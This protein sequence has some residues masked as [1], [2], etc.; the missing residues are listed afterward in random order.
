MERLSWKW[1]CEK[2]NYVSYDSRRVKFDGD[3][4]NCRTEFIGKFW[5]W[6]KQV[7]MP[8]WI[9]MSKTWSYQHSKRRKKLVP[10]GEEDTE[11][12]TLDNWRKSMQ[13]PDTAQ[14]RSWLHLKTRQMETAKIYVDRY[15]SI[16][17]KNGPN[18]FQSLRIKDN[19]Y[20]SIQYREPF[21][22]WCFLNTK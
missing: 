4:W 7:N 3:V 16:I 8:A 14:W 17:N 1:S 2:E 13:F 19:I 11:N 12:R 21:W 20:I 5:W 6:K 15:G 9:Q 10:N 22:R 18:F